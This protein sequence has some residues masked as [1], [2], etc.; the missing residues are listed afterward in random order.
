MIPSHKTIRKAETTAVEAYYKLRTSRALGTGR[1]ANP[2]YTKGDSGVLTP[3][4]IPYTDGFDI[5]LKQANNNIYTWQEMFDNEINNVI[6]NFAEG[7]EIAA[8]DHLFN[9]RSQVNN[10]TVEGVFNGATFVF[11][12]TDATNG[13]R[14]VQITKSVM[15]INKYV[16]PYMFFCDTVAYNK[17]EKQ[18]NQGTGN[19]ENL[20]F[21]FS[22]VEFIHSIDL[23]D[24]ATALGYTNGFWIA[25]PVGTISSLDWIPMQN[26]IGVNE[27]EA[28]YAQIQNPVDGL[29][30]ATYDIQQRSDQSGLNGQTQDLLY[31]YEFSIDIALDNAPLSNP[32]ETTLQAFGLV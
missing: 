1:Q 3:T 12:I 22:N 26:R 16:G 13:D 27:K 17:F 5:S 21:Q 4:W 7:L 29:T 20:S 8:T 14:A 23:N 10:A 19:S 2:S 11:D 25:V 28:T 9:N 32:N 18:A 24:D 30:Y 15:D 31:T 6:A